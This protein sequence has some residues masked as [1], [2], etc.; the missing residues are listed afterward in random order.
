MRSDLNLI[1]CRYWKCV[2]GYRQKAVIILHLMKQNERK[3]YNSIHRKRENIFYI[4]NYIQRKMRVTHTVYLYCYLLCLLVFFF[5]MSVVFACFDGLLIFYCWIA[6]TI[7][8][9]WLQVFWQIY[10]VQLCLAYFYLFISL[11]FLFMSRS[12]NTLMNS[13]S[14][15]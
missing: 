6:N 4:V 10:L 7:Y 9:L 1:P 15:S 14:V 12:L 11:M 8:V 13:S 2:N 3:E 5:L